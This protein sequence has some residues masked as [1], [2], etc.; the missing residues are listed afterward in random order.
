MQTIRE[1]DRR[2][3]NGVM[4]VLVW[5]LLVGGTLKINDMYQIQKERAQVAGYVSDVL[6]MKSVRKIIKDMPSLYPR[7]MSSEEKIEYLE[8]IYD[9]ILPFATEMYPVLWYINWGKLR[10]HCMITLANNPE[11]F[12]RITNLRINKHMNREKS[13]EKNIKTFIFDVWIPEMRKSALVLPSEI[14]RPYQYLDEYR[15][16]MKWNY[17]VI[18]EWFKS[19]EKMRKLVVRWVWSRT[20]IHTLKYLK[21]WNS[22]VQLKMWDNEWLP[23]WNRRLWDSVICV[24]NEEHW[25]S[26]NNSKE[27]I[28]TYRTY[29]Y[30]EKLARYLRAKMNWEIDFNRCILNEKD[31]KLLVGRIIELHKEW[32]N[33]SYLV[34][35]YN[36]ES[37]DNFIQLFVDEWELWWKEILQENINAFMN[38]IEKKFFRWD[39]WSAERK[40]IRSI[41]TRIIIEWYVANKDLSYSRS[42]KDYTE[43]NIA[44]WIKDLRYLF[45]D[46][47]WFQFSSENKK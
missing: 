6:A 26:T 10:N 12:S 4:W 28:D 37:L 23:I 42:N 39:R 40:E 1:V 31:R 11:N 20:R 43:F 29:W 44:S 34:R 15:D 18:S 46:I 33:F 14:E 47:E 30:A 36:Q 24:W 38:I 2:V 27:M 8:K 35:E 17:S 32:Y 3:R 21:N 5:G 22:I 41:C 16:A 19:K 7:L 13:L 9:D 25:Y 45:E